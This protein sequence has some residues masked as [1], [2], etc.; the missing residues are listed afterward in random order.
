MRKWTSL[1]C[2]FSLVVV[3]AAAGGCK[4]D[5]PEPVTFEETEEEVVVQ[6][7]D[8]GSLPE[9]VDL[10]SLIWSKDTGLQTVYFDFDKSD[11]RADAAATLEE[12]AAK[13]KQIPAQQNCI[14]RIAG[15][16][17]ERGTQEY[18]L[19]LGER[20]ALAVREYLIKLGCAGDRLITVS[21]GEEQPAQEGHDESAW[22]WNRR[23]EF[24][25]GSM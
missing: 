1:W 19:A 3:L 15:H 11:I 5:S 7:D 12:N 14:I 2:V 16:C 17:D 9:D 24:E 22:K 21:Y 18:N 13:I 4:S 25:K 6:Q 23:A 20:R 10:E 8:T